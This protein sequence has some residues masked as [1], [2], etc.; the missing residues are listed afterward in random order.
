M[1]IIDVI[2]VVFSVA[3]GFYWLVSSIIAVVV[4]FIRCSGYS[5]T[6]A[7]PAVATVTGI[8]CFSSLK[9]YFQIIDSNIWLA[10]FLLPDTIWLCGEVALQF[11]IRVLKL[12]DRALATSDKDA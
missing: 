4:F 6:S 8:V 11:R 10:A 9:S 12:P 5:S 1:I 7:V 3:A 2:M